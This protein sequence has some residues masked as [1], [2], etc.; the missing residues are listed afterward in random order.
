MDRKTHW[1]NVYQTKKSTEVSWYE[2]DPQQSLNLILGV[3]ERNRGRIID[4]GG[5]QSLLAERLLDA[6]FGQITV[7]DVS[8]AA[9]EATKARLGDRAAKVSW[10]FSD[11]VRADSPGDFDIWHDRAVLHFLTDPED[12]LRYVE[13]VRKSVVPGGYFIV[14]TFAFGG[15]EKCS[16]LTV[17]QYDEQS[18]RKL[19]GSD[20][21]HIMS[22]EYLHMT[23]AG[24]P[25]Q[26]YFG[27]Y[28]R[29]AQG[30]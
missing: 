21:R 8:S 4:V 6:G 12:Q 2:P 5:G 14:G 23:P 29:I 26:F 9:I 25:Q 19:L 30:G 10:V 22:V 1:D 15:P 16:G 17:Q 27:V 20:F 24:K 18:M 7:L 28:Q 11:I 3:C 13:L